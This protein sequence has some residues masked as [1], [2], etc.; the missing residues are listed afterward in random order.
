VLGMSSSCSLEKREYVMDRID[1]IYR[2]TKLEQAQTVCRLLE[3][4]TESC[5]EQSL[6]WGQLLSLPRCVPSAAV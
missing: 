6:A 3:T 2:E 1:A 5:A 4:R